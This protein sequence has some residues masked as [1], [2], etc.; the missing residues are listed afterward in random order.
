VRSITKK[1]AFEDSH[2]E[3]ITYSLYI[4]ARLFSILITVKELTQGS[5]RLTQGVVKLWHS[6]MCCLLL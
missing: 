6:V 5:A 3:F 2:R 4:L 1:V